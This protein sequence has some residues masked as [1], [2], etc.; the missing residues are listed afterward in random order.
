MLTDESGEESIKT[1]LV[2]DDDDRVIEGRC[3][4]IL[5]IGASVVVGYNTGVCTG[6]DVI[7]TDCEGQS[8]VQLR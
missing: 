4:G 8:L 5:K 6:G 1:F 7:D 3:R 2:L